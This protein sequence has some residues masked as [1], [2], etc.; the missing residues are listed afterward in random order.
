MSRCSDPR[1]LAE[2]D[3]V[4]F[5]I[6]TEVMAAEAERQTAGDNRSVNPAIERQLSKAA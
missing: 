1:D 2:L 5:F 6:V 4:T 3:P